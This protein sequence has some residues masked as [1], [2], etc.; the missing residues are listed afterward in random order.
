MN[1]LVALIELLQFMKSI[2]QIMVG[3]GAVALLSFIGIAIWR[4]LTFPTSVCAPVGSRSQA[5]NECEC[6]DCMEP[7]LRGPDTSSEAL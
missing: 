7:S 6:S 3:I 2:F 1:A 4:M 5:R